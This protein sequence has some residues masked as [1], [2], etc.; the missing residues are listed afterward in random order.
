[1][2]LLRNP[3]WTLAST[4]EEWFGGSCVQ[5]L[6]DPNNALATFAGPG[7]IAE[8][9]HRL[10]ARSVVVRYE[11]LVREPERELRSVCDY[12]GIDFEPALLSYDQEDL[13][14]RQQGDSKIY[15]HT[16]PVLTSLDVPP[17][18]ND[19]AN[20]RFGLRY[21][22]RLGPALFDALGYDLEETQRRLLGAD[23][24]AVLA[25]RRSQAR[26]ALAVGGAFASGAVRL[27]GHWL[28]QEVPRFRRALRGDLPT[29]S[30]DSAAG[31][32]PTGQQPPTPTRSRRV[33]VNERGRAG[34]TPR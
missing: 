18:F 27:T 16:A 19:P 29:S 3:L 34:T 6:R 22:E 14:Q 26:Y 15:E 7:A 1:M 28:K 2:F 11:D 13:G 4:A 31:A 21:I 20:Q 8:G 32:T 12:L 24:T 25:R 5:I 10:T 9:L 33:P 17:L 30:L 23:S